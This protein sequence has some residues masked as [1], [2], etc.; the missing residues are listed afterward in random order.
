MYM[1]PDVPASVRT[2]MLRERHLAKETRYNAVFIGLQDDKRRRI[3]SE[4]K[5]A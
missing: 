4:A 2:L 1:I 3:E 5:L